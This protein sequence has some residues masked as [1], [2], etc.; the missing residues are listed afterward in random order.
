MYI[1]R[2]APLLCILNKHAPT[3]LRPSAVRPSIDSKAIELYLRP[4]AQPITMYVVCM[5]VC[6]LYDVCVMYVCMIAPCA[7]YTAQPARFAV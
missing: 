2:I 7:R 6:M 3:H 4:S 1:T 5:Y